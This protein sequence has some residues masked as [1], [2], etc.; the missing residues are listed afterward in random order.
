MPRYL[1][2]LD[3]SKEVKMIDLPTEAEVQCSDG[4]VGLSTYIIGNPIDHQLMY[5]VVQCNLPPF[6]EYLVPI[7]HVEETT[8]N[9]IKLKCTQEEFQQ[10]ELFKYDEFIPTK[11]PSHLS[12]PYCVPIPGSVLEESAF[13]HVEHRNIPWDEQ[14]V[15]RGAGVEAT[16]GFIGQ[17]DE[18][19]INPN[20]MQV[21]HLVL[22]E[23]HILKQ[24]E[25]TIPV[26]QIDHVDEDTIYLKLDRRSV[27]ELPTTPIQ[28]WSL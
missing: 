9:L 19:L 2:K 27:E 25:I 16:D 18:L 14:A 11:M 1:K 23:W 15:R 26:S 3:Y 10:M 21:T 28:R 8:P 20:N 17:V 12:W 4:I 22:R 6:R 24:R 5:L 13:I 7:E